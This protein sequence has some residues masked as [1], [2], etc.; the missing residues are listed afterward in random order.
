MTSFYS[1]TKL[2][3]DEYFDITRNF[4]K[5]VDKFIKTVLMGTGDIKYY[6]YRVEFQARG[7]PHVHGVAWF[8]EH[9]KEEYLDETNGPNTEKVK[10]LTDKYITV[11]INT[12]NEKRNRKV[13]RTQKHGHTKTCDRKGECR[14]GFPHFPSDKTIIATPLVMDLSDE[15]GEGSKKISDAKEILAKVKQ[16]LID[17]KDEECNLSLKE[18]LEGLEVDYDAYHNALEISNTGTTVVLKRTVAERNINNYNRLWLDAWRANMDIQITLDHYAVISYIT[19]YLTKTENEMTMELLKTMTETREASSK[20][21]MYHCIRTYFRSLEVGVSQCTYKVVSGMNLKA[22]NVKT[23]FLATDYPQKRSSYWTPANEKKNS[24]VDQLDEDLSDEEEPSGS[25]ESEAITIPGREG[26]FKQVTSIHKKYSMRPKPLEKMCLAQFAS[27]YQM[28]QS[29][30]NSQD[31]IDNVS[32]KLSSFKLFHDDTPL[33]RWI[34]LENSMCMVSRK[35][36]P[37]V[38]KVHTS[39]KDSLEEVYAL[40]LMF[41]PWRNEMKDLR[42]NNPEHHIHIYEKFKGKL[43]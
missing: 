39:K 9:V 13:L 18:F 28:S 17:L 29:K 22:S 42:P 32:E 35:D 23:L 15:D 27:S 7:M 33:P 30:K 40:L 10:E 37:A 3:Q 41:L 16:A 21:A 1:L 4:D 19:D 6:T 11:S 12:G 8:K 36:F 25:N 38:L 14:F 26:K 2:F 20:E 34:L 31:F 24:N 5:K 43:F